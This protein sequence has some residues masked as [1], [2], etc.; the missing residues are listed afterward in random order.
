MQRKRRLAQTA[1]EMAPPKAQFKSKPVQPTEKSYQK[2]L[3]VHSVHQRILRQALLQE[4]KTSSQKIQATVPLDPPETTELLQCVRKIHDLCSS[5]FNLW[6]LAICKRSLL[7][8]TC[9]ATWFKGYET[10][11][12]EY[13]GFS[14]AFLS[15]NHLGNSNGYGTWA[16]PLL[17]ES[18]IHSVSARVLILALT[19]I[20]SVDFWMFDGDFPPQ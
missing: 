3:S 12:W 1:A 4:Q 6:G 14:F 8:S 19:F 13:E 18:K 11:D 17:P 9:Q 15:K 7:G 5:D 20:C 10:M 16:F 2:I